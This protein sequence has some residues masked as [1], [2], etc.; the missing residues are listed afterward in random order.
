MSCGLCRIDGIEDWEEHERSD[1]HQ[2]LLGPEQPLT[3]TAAD[4]HKHFMA[5]LDRYASEAE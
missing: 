2:E 1:R 3:G 5:I 4:L